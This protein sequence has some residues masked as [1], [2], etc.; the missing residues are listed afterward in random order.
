MAAALQWQER[1]F[2]N[3]ANVNTTGYKAERVSFRQIEELLLSLGTSTDQA[4]EGTL[5]LAAGLPE[6]PID[7]SQGPLWETDREL[8]V[9]IDGPAFFVVQGEQGE[10]LT[11]DGAFG[12]DAQRRL[13][14]KSGLL[15]LGDGGPIQLPPGQIAISAEGAIYVNGQRVSSIRLAIPE[16]N[17]QR[18]GEN[19]FSATT[20]QAQAGE[21]RVLQ[22]YLERANVNLQDEMAKAMAAL[23]TYEAAQRLLLA[24]NQTLDALGRAVQA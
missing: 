22:G 16:G 24:Q 8:D 13:V 3:V 19:M 7:L 1:I 18:A 11:R 2:R 15:V 9:A 17:L 5:P 14:T 6:G 12:L 4:R 20:R 10:L 23:R 21:A